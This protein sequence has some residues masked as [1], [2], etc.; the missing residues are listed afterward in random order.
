[1]T[2]ST[3][4]QLCHA[5]STHTGLAGDYRRL[6]V[7]AVIIHADTIPEPLAQ[8]L[9]DLYAHGH[10]R[11]RDQLAQ[12][13]GRLQALYRLATQRHTTQQEATTRAEAEAIEHLLDEL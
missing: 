11:Y 9:L 10:Q 8:S 6:M 2:P 4:D 3:R 1:M 12:A 7:L 5:I 13:N